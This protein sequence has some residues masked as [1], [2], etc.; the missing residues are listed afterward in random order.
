[1]WK[2]FFEICYFACCLIPNKRLRNRLR[3]Q[4]LFDWYGKYNA[5]KKQFPDLNFHHTKMIKGGWNIGFIVD[6]KYVF[7]IR[8][9]FDSGLPNEKITR[10]KRITDAF[11]NISTIQ[12]PKIEIIQ[13]GGY[14]FYKYDYIPGKNLNT[15]SQKTIEKHAWEWGKQLAE[16][17]YAI[18]NARP[19]EIED[20]RGNVIGD[21]W[22]HND[23]CNNVIVD[24]KTMRITGLID[25]EYSGWGLLQTEFNNCVAYSKKVRKSGLKIAIMSYYKSISA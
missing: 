21:G 19:T 3:T 10:E 11:Q 17:I 5:L 15:F 7:K 23:I 16:F 4:Q 24:K 22:N 14:T 1:M 20:L 2:L 12:I 25:W 18:H 13:T 9:K 8:K 6:N